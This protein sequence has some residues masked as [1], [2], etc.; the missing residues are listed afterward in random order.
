MKDVDDWI[1]ST[2]RIPSMKK[3]LKIFKESAATRELYPFFGW[4]SYLKHNRELLDND[5]HV[6][7]YTG[8]LTVWITWRWDLHLQKDVKVGLLL[9]HKMHLMFL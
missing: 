7:R 6:N 5:V 1:R 8:L 2:H 4:D 3:L 9:M